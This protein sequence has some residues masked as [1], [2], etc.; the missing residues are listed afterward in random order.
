MGSQ[1]YAQATSGLRELALSLA[2]LP[3]WRGEQ[4]EHRTRPWHAS[5]NFLWIV[6]TQERLN[7]SVLTR[8]RIEHLLA[9]IE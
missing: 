8:Q 3:Q 7:Q 4:R 1:D 6:F 9:S 2:G 5:L